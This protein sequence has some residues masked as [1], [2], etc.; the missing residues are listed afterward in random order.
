VTTSP[1]RA[2]AAADASAI[3]GVRGVPSWGAILIAVVF[4]AVGVVINVNAD[5]PDGQTTGWPL[6]IL[7]VLG[8][9]LAALAVRRGSVFTAMVQP[10][11][12][13]AVALMVGGM[14]AEKGLVFSGVDVV[15]SFPLM[16]V[17]TA[18][19]LVIGLVRLVAQPVSRRS[20]ADVTSAHA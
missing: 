6:R 12:V 4:T 9:A 3:P 5:L 15:K 14:L 19:G 18:V 8:V 1:S 20:P 7:F 13:L 2:L 17:G 16:I 10:P 11:L